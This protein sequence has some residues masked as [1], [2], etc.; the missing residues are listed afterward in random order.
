MLQILPS[1][2]H[3]LCPIQPS[4]VAISDLFKVSLL[5]EHIADVEVSQ[6]VVWFQGHC[7]L[8]VSHGIDNVSH[9]LVDHSSVGQH[10]SILHQL[11]K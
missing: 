4:Y 3:A 5:K 1:M 8:V 7:S 2:P 6:R 10:S 11:C 9:E